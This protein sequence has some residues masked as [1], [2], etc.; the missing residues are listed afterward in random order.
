MKAD[1]DL[2]TGTGIKYVKKVNTNLPPYGLSSSELSDSWENIQ[3]G[4]DADSTQ[5]KM[6]REHNTSRDQFLRY[7]IPL[8]ILYIILTLALVYDMEYAH[9]LQHHGLWEI[10]HLVVLSVE[11]GLVWLGFLLTPRWQQARTRAKWLVWIAS[12]VYLLAVFGVAMGI[13]KPEKDT[14]MNRDGIKAA[15]K[16]IAD[17]AMVNSTDMMGFG[18]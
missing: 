13:V 11:L 15:L 7:A 18:A 8:T 4:F 10:G 1:K 9:F 2:E 14:E 3:V 16:W 17:T 6:W 5:A 12:V